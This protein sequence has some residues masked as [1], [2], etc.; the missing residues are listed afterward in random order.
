[1][2]EDGVS[3]V[4]N[5]RGLMAIASGLSRF[6]DRDTGPIGRGMADSQGWMEVIQAGGGR[7]RVALWG[8]KL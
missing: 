2:K 1:M 5:A 8:S 3:P 4:L 6:V 7:E